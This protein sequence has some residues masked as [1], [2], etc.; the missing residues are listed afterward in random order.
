LNLP[1]TT[2]V[3]TI[4][5]SNG[6]IHLQHIFISCIPRHT[7]LSPFV[8]FRKDTIS[9]FFLFFSFVIWSLWS[10]TRFCLTRTNPSDIL[11]PELSETR[12]NRVSKRSEMGSFFLHHLR[13]VLMFLAQNR[14]YPPDDQPSI[15][16][17]LSDVLF[18]KVAF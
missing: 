8:I 7:L 4:A 5:D 2:T 16:V 12:L 17:W 3:K 9:M 10:T 11:T 6:D 1:P 14:P 15:T 18:T 13:S